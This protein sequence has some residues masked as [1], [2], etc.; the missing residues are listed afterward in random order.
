MRHVHPRAL[1]DAM[2]E[3][4]DFIGLKARRFQN[5]HDNAMAAAAV[6]RQQVDFLQNQL[7]ITD[8]R[9][10]DEI[11]DIRHEMNFL[12]FHLVIADVEGV[13]AD[14]DVLDVEGVERDWQKSADTDPIDAPVEDEIM[15]MFIV[16]Y[17]RGYEWLEFSDETRIFS[18]E[19]A[20][21][22]YIASLP[23]PGRHELLDASSALNVGVWCPPDVS[24]GAWVINE[25]N[26][27]G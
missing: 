16:Q 10:M 4:R 24:P 9:S 27:G 22:A 15:T 25:V 1:A 6:I 26:F 2:D 13:D 18:T 19:A 21:E 3:I 20:A 23:A 14:H 17:D 7:D 12:K 11:R 5:E 8:A